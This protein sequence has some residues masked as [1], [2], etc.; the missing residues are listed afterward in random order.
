MDFQELKATWVQPPRALK[1]QQELSGKRSPF[2][3]PPLHPPVWMSTVFLWCCSINSPKPPLPH[4]S[5][6]TGEKLGVSHSPKPHRGQHRSPDPL[7][8]TVG[9][10]YQ[11]GPMTLPSPVERA[12]LIEPVDT[13]GAHSPA[14]RGTGY[15]NWVFPFPLPEA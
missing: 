8:R 3:Q 1:A 4:P 15:W 2:F 6:F 9:H 13:E 10:L 12:D 7:L 14:R 5:H 11:P